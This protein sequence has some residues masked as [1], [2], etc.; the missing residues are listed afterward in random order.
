[1]RPDVYV[2]VSVF[3]RV[4][5]DIRNALDVAAQWLSTPQVHIQG[6]PKTA[7]RGLLTTFGL[8]FP[9]TGLKQAEDGDV[10]KK[11]GSASTK[12]QH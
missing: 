2:C 11:G 5:N 7:L 8:F 1:V 9:D 3:P 12:P 6:T 4:C 10:A